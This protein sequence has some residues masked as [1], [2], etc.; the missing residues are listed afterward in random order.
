MMTLP[1]TLALP[2]LTISGRGTIARLL[3]QCAAFSARGVLLH[4]S[5]LRKSGRLDSI[6]RTTPPGLSI[7]T[8][9]HSGGEPTLGDVRR[10]MS[11]ARAHRAQWLAAAG[12][13]SVLDLG[14]AAAGLFHS[15]H[16]AAA[17]HDGLQ[18]EQPGVPFIAAPTT[19]GTG[20]EATTVAV[21]I[22]EATGVKKSIRD[23]SFMARRTVQRAIF[24]P[25]PV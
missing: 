12:G 22:N 23:N 17:H 14:K 15:P 11:E 20:S 3:Q 9:E 8:V 16:D 1:A 5:S 19:A 24:P 18:V 21:L 4:G 13:G 6:M 7:C 2:L 10:V 25:R